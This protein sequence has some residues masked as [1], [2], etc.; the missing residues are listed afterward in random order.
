MKIDNM[1]YTIKHFRLCSLLSLVLL[2]ASCSEKEEFPQPMPESP[3]TIKVSAAA[4]TNGGEEASLEGE[5]DFSDMQACLFENGL[6]TRIYT[7]LDVSSDT[8]TLSLEGSSGTLYML[9]N[10][11][12]S[13]NLEALKQKGTTE[14]EWLEST[15]TGGPK[16]AI[17]FFTGKIDIT[18]GTETSVQT[19]SLERSVARLDL[20]MEA[21]ENVSVKSLTLKNAVQTAYLFAHNKENTPTNGTLKDLHTTFQQ[22][23]SADTRGVAYIYAQAEP[24]LKAEVEILSDGKIFTEDVELPLTLKRN[25]IYTLTVRKAETPSLQFELKVEEW[26]NGETT[27]RPNLGSPITVDEVLSTLPADAQADASG[28]HIALPA[29]ALDF[30]LAL[31]CDD[32]L[33][34][35]STQ[36][37]GITVKPFVT[38]GPFNGVSKFTVHKPL[39]P[40][41]YPAEENRIYFRRKG[42]K[43]TYEEDCITLLLQENPIRTEGLTFDRYSYTCDFGRYIDNELGR[44]IL[45]EGMDL[46]AEFEDED[47]WIKVEKMTDATN[48]YRIL[49]GWKPNDPKADGRKQA[50]KLVVSRKADGEQ[51]EAYTVMRRNY[52]LPVTLLNG[53]WWCRYNAINNSRSFDDQI[54]SANDPARLDGL[55]VQEYLKTC[56]QEEYLRLWNAAYEGNDGVALKAV[57]RNGQLTLDGWRSHEPDHINHQDSKALAPDGYEMP[58]F[59]DYRQIFSNFTIPT[60]WTGF[61]PQVG[62]ESN[63][64][65]IILD[66]RSGMELDGYP[67]NDL[68]S[69]SVRSA[70]GQDAEPLTFYG[71][72][73]QWNGSGINANWILLACSNPNTTGW[74]V[75]GSNASLEH[76]G[77]GANNTRLVRF[78]KSSVE[79]I[80]E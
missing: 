62:G 11:A 12:S 21:G 6:L 60:V 18:R 79:Y 1:I 30:T 48:T 72:G 67:L 16:G 17:N 35:A 44:F 71:V 63:R 66:K 23:L 40:P 64:C 28:S 36:T 78:K 20:R 52:G 7:N 53:I 13:I 69:F 55:T 3:T 34:F 70:K 15:V 58:T 25:T 80:Y 46:K 2:C 8:Y 38:E 32:E 57:N 61:N 5:N 49:A 41:G 27:L 59:E 47:S 26:Q 51:T 9:A 43:E 24:R 54:L 68:W 73:C 74:L 75:R 10:T 76:N 14:T 45:P 19:L 4:F 65:E 56:T 50:A 77:A 31:N 37:T 39:L 29:R 22:P 42:L 33:E